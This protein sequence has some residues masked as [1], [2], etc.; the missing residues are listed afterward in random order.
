MQKN[1]LRVLGINTAC[2]DPKT[3]TAA[4]KRMALKHHPDKGGDPAMFRLVKSAYDSLMPADAD[5]QAQSADRAKERRKREFVRR[6]EERR[7]L[8]E[9]LKKLKAEN[10]KLKKLTAELGKR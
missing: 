10:K 1:N 2:S 8:E 5:M 4:Y 6:A 9:E 7:K 3:I